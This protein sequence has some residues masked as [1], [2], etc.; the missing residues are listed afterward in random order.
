MNLFNVQL[1]ERVFLVYFLNHSK[2]Q[3]VF[4]HWLCARW[5]ARS[6]LICSRI[7]LLI[8]PSSFLDGF[9]NLH[10]GLLMKP[11]SWSFTVID[12]S[13]FANCYILSAN[14]KLFAICFTSR[15]MEFA[16]VGG[17]FIYVVML[18][19]NS[20]WWCWAGIS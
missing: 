8:I 18:F 5:F 15:L 19:F 12:A 1:D 16:N 3:L 9:I 6:L 4:F 10:V 20:F 11:S 14:F 2:T 7:F 17:A 13:A